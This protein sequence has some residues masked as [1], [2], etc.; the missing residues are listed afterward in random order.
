MRPESEVRSLRCQGSDV[1]PTDLRIQHLETRNLQQFKTQHKRMKS[2][3]LLLFTLSGFYLAMLFSC[4][5]SEKPEQIIPKGTY[6]SL[7]PSASPKLLLPGFINSPLNMYNGV[8]NPEGTAF[9][10]T[11]ETPGRSLIA[12]TSMND[13]GIWQEPVITSFSGSDWDYDPLYDP[14][15]NR[16]YFSSQ[17]PIVEDGQRGRTNIW[18][19][20]GND[21]IWSPPVYVPLTLDGDYHSSITSTGDIYFNIWSNGDIFKAAKVDT[22]YQISALPASING[23]K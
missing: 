1:G 12:S 5:V 9:Y 17:R 15:G 3:V 10:Y 6:M 13:D 16:L 21:N 23:K 7:E 8:F 14:S 20:E 19:V 2:A 22:G 18:F 11:V 4:Q